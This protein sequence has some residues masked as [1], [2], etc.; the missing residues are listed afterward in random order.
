MYSP[1]IFDK[2]TFCSLT[3]AKCM[4]KAV[5]LYAKNFLARPVF[6]FAD[7]DLREKRNLEIA[8][9]NSYSEY[10]LLNA[11]NQISMVLFGCSKLAFTAVN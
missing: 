4:R 11:N 2:I 10:H 5:S 3:G 7:T 1:Y 6:T 9:N 8:N